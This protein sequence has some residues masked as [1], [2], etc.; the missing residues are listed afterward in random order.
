[1]TSVPYPGGYST[2]ERTETRT[3]GTSLASARGPEASL[4]DAR[5]DARPVSGVDR[6]VAHVVRRTL[7]LARIMAVTTLSS[8]LAW[9]PADVFAGHH[10]RIR[11]VELHHDRHATGSHSVL[12]LR[13]LRATGA[14]GDQVF[15]SVVQPSQILPFVEADEG[16]SKGRWT[17]RRPGADAGRL[18]AYLRRELR[19]SGRVGFFVSIHPHGDAHGRAVHIVLHGLNESVEPGG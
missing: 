13:T 4:H 5:H 6:P 17:I 18:I 7:V 9:A 15:A 8:L 10:P 1:V 3:E 19:V 12:V 11:S 14:V 2:L 16:P